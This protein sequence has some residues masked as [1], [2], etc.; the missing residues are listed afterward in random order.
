MLQTERMELKKVN[1]FIFK[2]L[3]KKL[4]FVIH[5]YDGTRKIRLLPKYVYRLRRHACG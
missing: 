5:F 1:V 2:T 3:L 4:G